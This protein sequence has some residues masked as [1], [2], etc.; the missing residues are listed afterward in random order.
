MIRD[1]GYNPSLVSAG[2]TTLTVSGSNLEGSAT[3]QSAGGAGVQGFRGSAVTIRD[4][5]ITR[6]DGNG[7]SVDFG[8]AGRSIES[9]SATRRPTACG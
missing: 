4:T 6:A 3:P 5:V 8:V 7:V 1:A 2:V 9:R